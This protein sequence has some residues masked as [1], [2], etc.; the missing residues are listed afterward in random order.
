MPITTEL[1]LRLVANAKQEKI[2]DRKRY[3]RLGDLSQIHMALGAEE[4][5]DLL[6]RR[7]QA[8]LETMERI[9]AE[10]E[11]KRRARLLR[12]H[13]RELAKSA[14]FRPERVA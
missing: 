14:T 4:L 11:Q 9:H 13:Q 2:A 7:L 12:S 6:E 1:F 5:C 3:S 8:Y 10:N